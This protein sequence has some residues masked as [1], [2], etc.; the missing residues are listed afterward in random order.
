MGFPWMRL[1]LMLAFMP[2]SEEGVEAKLAQAAQLALQWAL[3]ET[4][5]PLARRLVLGTQARLGLIPHSVARQ[6]RYTPSPP[7]PPPHALTPPAQHGAL[8]LRGLLFTGAC[9]AAT[10]GALLR[11][12][13]S[14]MPLFILFSSGLL[15]LAQAL[16]F[17]R[18]WVQ[19]PLLAAALGG[20]WAWEGVRPLLTG[21]ALFQ[22]L[23]ALSD[24]LGRHAAARAAPRRR[25]VLQRLLWWAALGLTLP[26]VVVALSAM[27]APAQLYQATTQA[28]AA[29]APPP[30]AGA[31]AL[32]QRCLGVGRGPEDPWRTL[33]LARGAATAAIRKR[34]RELSLQFHP[35]KVGNNPVKLARFLQIQA[36]VEALTARGAREAAAAALA[37]AQAEAHREAATRCVESLGV[38]GLWA[39]MSLLGWIGG[40][41]GRGGAAAEEAAL[42]QAQAAQ[43]AMGAGLFGLTPPPTPAAFGS[44]FAFAAVPRVGGQAAPQPPQPPPPP[45]PQMPPP[46]QPAT[47]VAARASPTA[48]AAAPAAP[49]GLEGVFAR[50]GAPKP[51]PAA[52]AAKTGA[53]RRA[54]KQAKAKGG[55]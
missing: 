28:D 47:P 10:L 11:A 6:A 4:V 38:V 39:A 19:L 44:P 15:P 53:Q 14:Q 17:P 2:Q 46:S 37:R 52:A 27:L 30:L 45:P 49:A 50:L 51:K 18:L 29:G 9:T 55:H 22:L 5:T 36:A 35:D 40:L 24:A 32:L 34:A 21:L 23:P 8:R 13:H 12:G 43:A 48:Q 16:F 1:V 54:E 7:R 31:W 20:V 3:A 25:A 33:G 41:L 42:A 26:L